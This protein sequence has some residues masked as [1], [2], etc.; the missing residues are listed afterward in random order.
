[1]T[2]RRRRHRRL[3]AAAAL[4]GVACLCSALATDATGANV[5]KLQNKLS[6]T[7]SQLSGA[8]SQ[9]KSI[10]SRLGTLNSQVS[11]LTGQIRLV[12]SR[13]SAANA[14]LATYQARLAAVK[15]AVARER[16]HLGHL[17]RVLARARVALSYELRSQ[18]EQPQESFISLIVDAHGFQQLLDSLQYLSSTKRQEQA[19]I[20]FT[21]RARARAHLAAQR[22]GALEESDATAA[23]D[24]Q[25]QAGALAGMGALLDSRQAALAHARAAQ[26]AAL[27]AAQAHGAALQ[28]AIATI[29]KQVA[30]AKLA[31]QRIV[32]PPKPVITEPVVP[33]G[34]TDPTT[35]AGATGSTNPTTS[36]GAGGGL[37][38][39]GGSGSSGSGSGGS[40]SG[41]TGA[42]T[43]I[44]GSGGW[45]I[46]YPVVLCE[47]GGQNLPPNSAGA[48]GYYQIMPGTWRDYGGSGPAAYLASKAEQDA[49]AARIWNNGAGASN[50]TCAAIVG[51]T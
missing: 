32:P 42:S 28:A 33:A 31:E 48:S 10:Q 47:S 23:A 12:Q 27:A 50:W 19:I 43:S 9:Q 29:Q 51:I 6:N 7:Q 14:Q 37:G 25:T 1:M 20:I 35:S 21:R 8:H 36:A 46:P 45:A 3:V 16:A 22:L 30:A 39:S 41:G 13:E 49:V 34:S 11:A 17:R 44:G 40:G 26:S 15:L 4:T 24:A 18:Y 5:T 38:T 2:H